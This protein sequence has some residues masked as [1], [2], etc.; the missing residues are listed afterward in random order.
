MKAWWKTWKTLIVGLGVS[1]A[2]PIALIGSWAA[3]IDWRGPAD[4]VEAEVRSC[5]E[6]AEVQGDDWNASEHGCQETLERAGLWS[7]GMKPAPDRDPGPKPMA[8]AKDCT[9][10]FI[11]FEEDTDYPNGHWYAPPGCP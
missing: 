1:V 10:R 2:L 5:L 8:S 4:E 3:F 11:P 7:Y 6:R 9:P